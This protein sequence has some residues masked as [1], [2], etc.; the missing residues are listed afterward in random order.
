MDR[1]V[2]WLDAVVLKR[3]LWD[4]LGIM[5]SDDHEERWKTFH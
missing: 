1:I 4:L 3:D 5:F 2:E